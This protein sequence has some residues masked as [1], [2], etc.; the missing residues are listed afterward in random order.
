MASVSPERQAKNRCMQYEGLS[1]VRY[2]D[3]K[4][5]SI[6]Y[7]HHYRKRNEC[8]KVCTPAQAVAWFEKDWQQAYDS[9][10]RMCKS[11][12]INPP[13]EPRYSALVELRYQLGRPRFSKFTLTWKA[14]ARGDW[15]EVERQLLYR[16]PPHDMRETPLFRDSPT[17]I[18]AIAG[19]LARGGVP[20]I[21]EW[22]DTDPIEPGEIAYE[23]YY[24]KTDGK[25]LI[26]G[27][28]LP[29]WRDLRSD[30]QDAWRAAA[31]AVQRAQTRVS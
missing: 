1:L 28:R 5:W 29:L 21:R 10:R 17:R 16:R 26:S 12:G 13:A 2:P 8:P 27:A 19:I 15:D 6:G 3:K 7:G 14:I 23:A 9:I 24:S 18:A 25:S 30:I 4:G 22:I 20:R 31:L 11:R